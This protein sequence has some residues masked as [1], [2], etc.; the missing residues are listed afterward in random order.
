MG[1]GTAFEYV[2][3][4]LFREKQFILG[5]LTISLG[6]PGLNLSYV[7]NEVAFARHKLQASHQ[8][9]DKIGKGEKGGNFF[10]RM[11]INFAGE[12]PRKCVFNFFKRE[13]ARTKVFTLITEAQN[14][15]TESP[16]NTPTATAPSVTLSNNDYFEKY[17][18][19]EA[20]DDAAF[21]LGKYEVNVSQGELL[22]RQALLDSDQDLFELY[23]SVVVTGV[24][25]ANDFW[26]ARVHQIAEEKEELTQTRGLSS[27]LTADVHASTANQGNIRYELTPEHMTRIFLEQPRVHRIYEQKVPHEL[28]QLDFWKLYFQSKYFHQDREVSE[29]FKASEEGRAAA[30]VFGDFD[31]DDDYDD[32]ERVKSLENR[33]SRPKGILVDPEV[34]LLYNLTDEPVGPANVLAGVGMADR[35]GFGI[36]DRDPAEAEKDRACREK[37]RKLGRKAKLSDVKRLQAKPLESGPIMSRYNRHAKLVL[38]DERDPRTK[39]KRVSRMIDNERD[40]E[41]LH[42]LEEAAGISNLPSVI[43]LDLD[44]RSAYLAIG[45]AQTLKDGPNK[46]T[47]NRTTNLE[48]WGPTKLRD[49]MPD[50]KTAINILDQLTC[51]TSTEAGDGN[52]RVENVKDNDELLR[53]FRASNEVRRHFWAR[54][55]PKVRSSENLETQQRVV[56]LQK[57]IDKLKECEIRVNAFR[58]YARDDGNRTLAHLLLDVKDQINKCTSDWDKFYKREKNKRARRR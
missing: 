32:D 43:P 40:A 46:A 58:T 54:F 36:V 57:I 9:L 7:P 3:V 26:L 16:A 48:E 45:G 47:S 14:P 55:P 38:P 37:L 49:I 11:E 20:N 30:K 33:G 15:V 25:S 18:R 39:R 5:T 22:A 19:P 53:I 12:R 34:D 28:S 44:D 50:S 42:D 6:S 29:E 4:G 17:R 35:A 41:V 27:G 1:D 13:Q 24:M 23:K 2:N 10:L 51:G 52:E 21:E 8:L 31:N 56:Q